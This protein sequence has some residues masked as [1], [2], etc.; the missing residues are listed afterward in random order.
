M[1][2]S[3]FVRTNFLGE[4]IGISKM[5][6][7]LASNGDDHIHLNKIDQ[8]RYGTF[9]ASL[10]ANVSRYSVCGLEDFS[11]VHQS[12]HQHMCVSASQFN[13]LLSIVLCARCRLQPSSQI[14][15]CSSVISS[16]LTDDKPSKIDLNS[17]I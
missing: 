7:L 16:S 6:F 1:S 4:A 12:S 10:M 8:R 9:V 15:C 14:N 13:L 17:P 3:L 2:C 5:C 11:G